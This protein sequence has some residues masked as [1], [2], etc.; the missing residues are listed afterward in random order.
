MAETG[1]GM[2]NRSAL[3]MDRRAAQPWVWLTGGALLFFLVPLIGT[4]LL[5]LQPDLYFLIYFTAAVAWFAVFAWSNAVALHDLWRHGFG[6]SLAVGAVVGLGLAALVLSQEATGHP[7][8]WRFAFE[9]VWRG[10]AYGAVDALTLFVF[11]AAVAHL[12]M[13]GNRQGALRKLGFAGLTMGLSML[14]TASYHLGY[15]EFRDADLRSP[16]MGAIAAN[17]PAALTGNPVG[18]VVAHSTVHVVAVVHQREGGTTQM[19]PPKVTAGYPSRGDADVAAG[20]AV[21]WLFGAAAMA[22]VIRRRS[23]RRP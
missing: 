19:L 12:L 14:V 1:K 16:E 3:R 6:F 10:V 22:L 13:R 7:E 5:G 21:L 9:I 18:S 8:G 11:P 2:E 15:A 4:G 17:I 23:P 20:L